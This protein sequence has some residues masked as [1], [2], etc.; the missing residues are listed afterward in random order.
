MIN[1]ASAYHRL[2]DYERDFVDGF[3]RSLENENSKHFERLT[4]TL[5]RVSASVNLDELD[6]R[7]RLLFS[8][9]L[10]TAAIRERVETIAAERDLTHDRIIR[11]HAKIAF[12]NISHFFKTGEDGHIYFD[13][14]NCT[15]DDWAAVQ[16]IDYKENFG[17]NG[18]S[19]EVKLRMH[20]KQ[21]S[22]DTLSKFTGLDKPENPEYAA[23][24][25]LPGVDP[26]KLSTDLSDADLAEEYARFI[27]DG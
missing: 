5:Q 27:G 6:E 9:P 26:S 7:T 22:L 14:I 13:A 16:S 17:K 10:V 18:T 25:A 3:L 15:E 19:K 23:Y 24:K 4:T 1:F 8:K 21:I 12:S 20:G 2:A 11:E